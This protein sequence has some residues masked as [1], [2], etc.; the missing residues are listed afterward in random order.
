M[1]ARAHTRRPGG[2]AARRPAA[3]RAAGS[4]D[5]RL[6]GERFAEIQRA[7]L[8]A[9]AV[10]AI[11]E[12][13]YA[14]TSVADITARAR[15][16]RRTFYELFPDREA[17]LL[18][19]VDDIV[20]LIAAELAAAE[21]AA[22]P[23]RERVHRGLHIILAFLDREPVLARVCVVQALRGGP[24]ILA[25]REEVLAQLAAAIDDGRLHGARGERCTALQA[26][27]LV[28]AA[29]A[30]V[31]AR[32]LKGERAPLT[33][34]VGELMAM[35][36]LPYE[37]AATAERERRRPPL[38]TRAAA[39]CQ[40]LGEGGVADPLGGVEMRLTYRTARVLEGIADHPGASNREAGQHAGIGDPGQVSK[41]LARL[42]RLGLLARQGTGRV[43]GEPN[44]WT[45][46][47]RGEHVAESLRRHGFSSGGGAGGDR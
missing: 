8:L 21:L 40:P 33:A 37:G 13:G 32:L 14:D 10:R 42:E 22:L 28:G 15:V 19:V 3:R 41:L 1:T 47:V 30:I 45:L 11:D 36:V 29:F 25:R 39:A 23:W 44:A 7:R 34:L 12:L 18:R 17:C 4:A 26:E 43:K 24:P 35:I 16:S 31:Y 5:G 6:S 38:S 46:T 20:G 27:G 9:A 2:S